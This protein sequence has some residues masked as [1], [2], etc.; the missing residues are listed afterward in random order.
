MTY[1]SWAMSWSH[2]KFLKPN[3]PSAYVSRQWSQTSL[4]GVTSSLGGFQPPWRFAGLLKLE[5]ERLLTGAGD[6]CCQTEPSRSDRVDMSAAAAVV[7]RAR[8]T[9]CGVSCILDVMRRR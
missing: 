7:A 5:H 1:P 4:S 9:A 3:R 2:P 8:R 6:C